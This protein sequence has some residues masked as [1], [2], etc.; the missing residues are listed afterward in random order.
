VLPYTPHIKVHYVLGWYK[1]IHWS[2][3]CSWKSWESMCILMKL[4]KEKPEITT[5]W[6]P[7]CYILHPH[8]RIF[9]KW[10]AMKFWERNILIQCYLT[11]PGWLHCKG[12]EVFLYSPVET[13]PILQNAASRLVVVLNRRGMSSQLNLEEVWRETSKMSYLQIRRSCL[14]LAPKWL[15]CIGG[16][17]LAGMLT[18]YDQSEKTWLWC[19]SEPTSPGTVSFHR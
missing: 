11:F 9:T 14:L 17:S 8:K 5:P 16:E 2:L 18:Q 12:L 7:V 1:W 13:F 15:V 19:H 3:W 4:G 10:W 6:F